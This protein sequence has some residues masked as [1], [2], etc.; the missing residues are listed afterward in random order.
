MKLYSILNMNNKNID[1]NNK[2]KPNKNN[3]IR[4]IKYVILEKNT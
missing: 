2:N 1:L 4:V 3:K